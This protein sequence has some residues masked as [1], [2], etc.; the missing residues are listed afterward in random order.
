MKTKIGRTPVTITPLD[1]KRL[2][3]RQNAAIAAR[4]QNIQQN[5]DCRTG[6][7]TPTPVLRE[8]RAFTVICP[9]IL[10]VKDGDKYK[11]IQNI[12]E[13]RF[14]RTAGLKA[15]QT[16]IVA[17]LQRQFMVLK[18][19]I[20]Y[21]RLVLGKYKDMRVSLVTKAHYHIFDVTAATLRP[22][23]K[24][25][26]MIPHKVTHTQYIHGHCLE[27]GYSANP[28]GAEEGL[29]ATHI[30]EPRAPD[31][32]LAKAEWRRRRLKELKTEISE[33]EKAIE[34]MET[35]LEGLSEG[36]GGGNGENENEGG[37]D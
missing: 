8:G 16:G 20:P 6:N 17:S 35:W 2:S 3:R 34:L 27:T 37:G 18:F 7:A 10:G 4:I 11:K 32:K 23:E 22:G 33:R 26:L 31:G 15:V 28:F 9:H 1:P 36:E 5:R 25:T 13:N 30:G 21:D 14:L 19:P 24:I 12:I 29:T